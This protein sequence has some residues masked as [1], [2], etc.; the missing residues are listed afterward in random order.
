INYGMDV[1]IETHD[2]FELER[3]LL[4]PTGMIGINNR[5]LKTL[6][7]SLMTTEDLVPLIPPDRLVVSE[8]G[9]STPADIVRMQKHNVHCFLV[10]ESLLKQP[11]VT[12]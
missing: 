9:L 3:A 8:S 11:D 1:L 12:S 7:T 5:N 2:R 10:G 4:L 6:K